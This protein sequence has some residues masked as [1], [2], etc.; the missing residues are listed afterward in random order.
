[1]ILEFFRQ[2]VP[3]WERVRLTATAPEVG[4]RE[5]RRF[6]GDYQ[7]TV[8][9]LRQAVIP[10]DT[11]ALGGYPIDIHS[12][13]GSTVALEHV[14]VFGIPYRC[15]T[16]RGVDNLLVVG[17][18]IS[19]THEALASIRVMGQCMAMGHA[20]GIAA[21]LALGGDGNARSVSVARLREVLLAQNAQ[22]EV[23]PR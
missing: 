17:R 7:L 3:G 16:P 11:I 13:D 10:P 19:A 9:D 14:E 23:P 8:D 22:L 1:M 15:L 2:Y 12:P 18:C 20:G 4:V 21:H 5:T 6:E